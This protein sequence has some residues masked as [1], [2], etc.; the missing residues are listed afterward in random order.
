M[1]LSDSTLLVLAGMGLP[2]W[3][4]RGLKQ[5]YRP[6]K[7]ANAQARTIN[8]EL[9]D[10]SETQFQKYRSTITGDD[11]QHPS[12]DDIFP[13]EILVVDCVFEFSY[14]DNTGGPLRPVVPGSERNE[15]GFEFYRPQLTMMVL[16]FRINTDEWEANVGWRLELE[17][18]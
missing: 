3:S 16:D 1:A 17:E 9:I 5:T 11:M 18:I 10:L 13:G 8:G 12:L 4:A 6:I 15:G 14:E 7:Q 2:E